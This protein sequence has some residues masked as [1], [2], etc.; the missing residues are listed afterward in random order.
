MTLHFKG[1]LEVVPISILL[2]SISLDIVT[3]TH[4]LCAKEADRSIFLLSNL[5]LPKT[6]DDGDSYFK[7]DGENGKIKL[8][9]VAVIRVGHS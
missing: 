8:M 9:N 6:F 1:H 5:V 7:E 4:F 3:W 2:I